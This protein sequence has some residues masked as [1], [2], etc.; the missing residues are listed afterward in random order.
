MNK[1]KIG[2]H[3]A[4]TILGVTVATASVAQETL[5]FATTHNPQTHFNREVLT[6]WA[7]RVTAQ[8]GDTVRIQA[9]QGQAIA[10]Q[11]NVINR[12]LD[13]AAQ[14]GWAIHSTAP[15][16]FPRSSVTYIPGLLESADFSNASEIASV[17]LWRT[18]ESG[19]LDAEYQDIIPLALVVFPQLDLHLNKEISSLAEFE[20][21]RLMVGSK[22][23]AGVAEQLG[24]LPRTVMPAD[25]YQSLSR[26]N[27]DGTFNVWTA[28]APFRLGE[29]THH[30]LEMGAGAPTAMLFMSR[31]R[32]DALPAAAQEA[33]LAESGES[34]S[35]AVGQVLDRVTRE[36]KQ[37]I[38]QD[39]NRQLVSLS[40]P[41]RGALALIYE[42]ARQQWI[43]ETP[44]GQAVYQAFRIEIDRMR[45]EMRQ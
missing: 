16:Q 38:E 36:L 6:P 29:V 23:D 10:N 25:V 39:E 20:G 45:A 37:D 35:R 11:G 7:E 5:R 8:H 41:D 43:A 34:I 30:H 26:G 12:V 9:I 33:I 3:I 42:D 4:A 14:I 15:G 22:L 28:F 19:V 27:I 13:N 18:Y 1:N 31:E 21:L 44:D 17:A 40:G 2:R 32:F 24:A